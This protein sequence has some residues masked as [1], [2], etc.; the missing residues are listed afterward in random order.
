[1]K[2]TAGTTLVLML[3]V[4]AAF[5]GDDAPP[6]PGGEQLRTD[7]LGD[8]LPTGAIARIGTARLWNGMGYLPLTFTPDGKILV[9]GDSRRVVR[10]WDAAT[11]KQLRLIHQDEM[12]GSFALSPDGKTLVTSSWQSPLLRLWDISTGKE[13]RQL[14]G[15]P[16]GNSTVAFSAD[17]K[18]LVIGCRE[19]HTSL[20]DPLTGQ[21][22]TPVRYR[23]EGFTTAPWSTRPALTIDGERAALGDSKGV[24]H[25]WETA[26][27]KVLWHLGDPPIGSSDA[28]FS[29]D[30][31]CNRI[32]K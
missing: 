29:P 28:V 18:T 7:R 22:Q 8:P 5:A 6:R 19:G 13:L 3:S 20:W 23:P 21:E 26:S 17:G 9:S 25:V 32:L 10:L 11:G 31:L 27:T 4:L 1:M 2:R 15:D 30:G 16:Q 14:A 12:V 24:M